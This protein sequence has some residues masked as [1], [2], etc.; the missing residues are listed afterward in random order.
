MGCVSEQRLSA[1][2]ASRKKHGT[3]IL[4]QSGTG[5]RIARDILFVSKARLNFE[6]EEKKIK[7]TGCLKLS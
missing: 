2:K 7:Q 3:N 5:Q 1:S 6:F 4:Q